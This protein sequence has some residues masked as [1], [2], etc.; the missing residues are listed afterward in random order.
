MNKWLYILP[1]GSVEQNMKD[2]KIKL[3]VSKTRL[4]GMLKSGT[5]TRITNTE[6][7][8]GYGTTDRPN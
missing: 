8:N 3:G 4:I 1:D 5:V 7:L 6:A 2:V